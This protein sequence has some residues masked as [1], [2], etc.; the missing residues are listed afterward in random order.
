MKGLIV[1]LKDIITTKAV[2]KMYCLSFALGFVY[3]V[4]LELIHKSDS[5]GLMYT[6]YGA[7]VYSIT[8][9]AFLIIT[10]FCYKLLRIKN[11]RD[12]LNK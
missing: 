5:I 8:I 4:Y 7:L 1:M 11:K 6:L 10:Y 2:M 9:S 12:R 3:Q